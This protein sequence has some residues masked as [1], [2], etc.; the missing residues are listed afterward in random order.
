MVPMPTL[1]KTDKNFTTCTAVLT[2]T[3][4]TARTAYLMVSSYLSK[5]AIGVHRERGSAPLA[6]V[7]I[8]H[9]PFQRTKKTSLNPRMSLPFP[10]LRS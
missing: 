9:D 6:A 8:G 10:T 3:M 5:S 2:A 1:T 4:R 7:V